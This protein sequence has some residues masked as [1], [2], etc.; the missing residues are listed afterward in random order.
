MTDAVAEWAGGEVLFAGCTDYA[1][2]GGRAGGKKG[3][4]TPAEIKVRH[5]ETLAAFRR[6]A[7][8]ARRVADS[9]PQLAGRLQED[10][11]YL[12]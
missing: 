11:L 6:F 1:R 8:W 12:S 7:E 5:S 4:Q 9:V 2:A 3:K 10:P